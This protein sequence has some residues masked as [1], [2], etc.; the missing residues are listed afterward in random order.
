MQMIEFLRNATQEQREELARDAGTTWGYLYQL[1]R[2]NDLGPHRFASLE[3]ATDIHEASKRFA[4]KYKGQKGREGKT[5]T[6]IPRQ[7][8]VSRPDLL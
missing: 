5:F 1:A 6:P 8:L 2:Y 4:A 7:L 3:L